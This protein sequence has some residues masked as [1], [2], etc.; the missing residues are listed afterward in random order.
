MLF[1]RLLSL[2]PFWML[3]GLSSVVRVVLFGMMGYRKGV[4]LENLQSAFPEK[5]AAEIRKIQRAFEAAFCD[6]WVE[7]IKLLTI[8]RKT[9]NRRMTG[10]WEL[11]RKLG[12][13]GRDVYVLLGH[14]FNWEW[15]F[16]A[17]QWNISQTMAGFYLPVSN[18]SFDRLMQRIR[19]RG[20]GLLVSLKNLR[21]GLT[22]LQGKRFVAGLI[23]DQNPSQPESALWLSFMHREAPFFR[24]PEALARKANAAV[25]FAEVVRQ[26]RGR[27]Q[28]L[29][30]LQTRHAAETA[31]EEIIRRYV[32]HLEGCLHRQPHNYLWSHRRWKLKRPT[33]P[34][35]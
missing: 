18:K 22:A 20:G 13:E 16:V 21:A 19:S 6:Q 9:L 26:R 4:V 5:D 10:N 27:Y 31:P 12:E 8:S 30:T 33:P 14:Q 1:F 7:T 28:V 23:A 35:L 25:V 34:S 2:L 3:Y 15:A 32:Q 11:L 29:L 17:T 24:G